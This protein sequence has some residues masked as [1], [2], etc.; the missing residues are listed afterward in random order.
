MSLE[1]V[2]ALK[3]AHLYEKWGY[4]PAVKV[5]GTLVFISGQVGVGE[6]GEVVSDPHAQFTQAFENLKAVLAQAGCTFADLV[7]ITTFHVD[8]HAHIEVLQAVKAQYLA[9]PYPA[10]TAIGA[11][12]LAAPGL[13]F[14]IRAVARVP[15]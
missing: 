7:E 14:E 1:H 9:P 12:D 2:P 5:R 13:L 6:G 4:A 15:E 3:N 10:W 11:S 8:M